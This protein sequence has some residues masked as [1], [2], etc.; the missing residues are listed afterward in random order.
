MQ[1]SLLDA[2][3]DV[4]NVPGE[5]SP[6]HASD[7]VIPE[8]LPNVPATHATHAMLAL[9]PCCDEYVPESQGVHTWSG[10]LAPRE[11]EK[12]PALQKSQTVAASSCE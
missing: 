8:P 1:T 9:A 7:E 4:E 10:R 5:H 11:V 12:V 2:R 3:G 6:R